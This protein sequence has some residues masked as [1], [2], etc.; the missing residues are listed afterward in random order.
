MYL[1][2]TPNNGK[3]IAI[4]HLKGRKLITDVLN[5]QANSYKLLSFL[6]KE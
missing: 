3:F 5:F 6:L 4:I 2:K 1:N